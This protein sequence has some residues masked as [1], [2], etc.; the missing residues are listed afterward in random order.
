MGK[1]LK[2]AFMWITYL[3]FQN[4]LVTFVYQVNNDENSG[5]INF[6]LEVVN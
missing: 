1:L 6:V 2:K 3:S 4:K 5:F